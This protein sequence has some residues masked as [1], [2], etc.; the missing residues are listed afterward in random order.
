MLPLVLLGIAGA[1]AVAPEDLSSPRESGGWV[2]DQAGVLDEATVA[3]LNTLLAQ[4]EA[5]TTVEAPVVTVVD[6]ELTPKEFTTALFA[7]WGVGKAGTDNGLLTVMVIEQRRL[8]METGYGLEPILP[9]AW[10]GQMQA[11]EMVPHFKAGDYGAGIVAGI[12]ASAARL[13]ERSLEARLGSRA[14]EAT[15]QPWP[16]APETVYDAGIPRDEILLGSAGFA[17]LGLLGGL[18]L[19]VRRRRRTCPECGVYMP[20]LDE[21]ADDAHLEPGQITEE[22]VGSVNWKVHAC[23]TCDQVRVFRSVSLFSGHKRCPKCSNRTRTSTRTTISPATY[24]S[25]GSARVTDTCAHCSYHSSRTVTI[26]RKQRPKSSSSSSSRSS[27]SSSSRS[28]YSSSSSRSSSRSSFGGG[29]SGGGGA[30][31]SW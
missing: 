5:D 12:E 31:S 20:M 24:S 28:S 3:R 19:I 7:R 10:L 18:F 14:E 2:V 29:R 26:P 30:G 25:S 27:W 1:V 4:L 11:R 22:K 23:P 17:G 16:E 9:D 13:R 21:E 15:T 8:E 6:T